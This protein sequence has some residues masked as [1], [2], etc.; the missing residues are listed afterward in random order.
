MCIAHRRRIGVPLSFLCYLHI[1]LMLFRFG[2]YSIG[3]SHVYGQFKLIRYSCCGLLGSSIMRLHF[4]CVTCSNKPLIHLGVGLP[5]SSEKGRLRACTAVLS[6]KRH[7]SR[8]RRGQRMHK[9]ENGFVGSLG[10]MNRALCL[11]SV[12]SG[13]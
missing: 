2:R 11:A 1:C 9:S 13:V 10:G 6:T 3:D 12:E 4:S 8:P 7:L 5:L